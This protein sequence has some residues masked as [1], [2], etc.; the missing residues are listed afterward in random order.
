MIGKPSPEDRN[1]YKEKL[2]PYNSIREYFEEAVAEAGVDPF[3][4]DGT[5]DTRY[6]YDE[7]NER[8]NAI[9]NELVELG[10][11]KGDRISFMIPNVPEFIFAL[12]GAQKVG[13]IPALVNPELK[14]KT[15]EHCLSLPDANLLVTTT[16][17][18]DDHSEV[19]AAVDYEH[20]PWLIEGEKPLSAVT[21]ESTREFERILTEG[22]TT[23]PPDFDIVDDDPAVIPYSSG[24]TGMPKGILN[25]QK[26]FHLFGELFTD[27]GKMETG[28][29]YLNALP[30][31]HQ[32][33]LWSI[34]VAIAC[35]GYNVIFESFSISEFWER[36]DTYNCSGTC[37]VNE[38]GH[39]L[40]N[41]PEQAD[42]AD[43]PL[44][45]ALIFG[46]PKEEREAFESRFGIEYLTLYGMTEIG[47]AVWSKSPSKTDAKPLSDG[48]PVTHEVKIVDEHDR[49]LGPGEVGEVLAR[50]CLDNI[51]LKEY[52]DRPK[53]TVEAFQNCWFHTGDMGRLDEDGFFYYEGREGD[54]IRRKGENIS[55]AEIETV[56]N[57]LGGVFESAVIGVPDD[58]V[59]EEI[60]LHVITTEDSIS[61][62]DVVGYCAEELPGFQM[63]RYV[64]LL[65]EFPRTH[66]ERVQK[67]A[68]SERGEDGLTADT[69]DEK[70]GEFVG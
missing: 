42:D 52:V 27:Y 37:L 60:K 36:A 40:Y 63:P 33:G 19:R 48:R 47:G 3:V 66:T 70:A 64:E 59:G 13:V 45:W 58:Q 5:T 53:R 35:R 11:G 9:A 32:G 4:I 18:I 61:V 25:P 65:E 41:Q 43:N 49:E 68:L 51:I 50:P 34:Y 62:E 6:T 1:T 20:D 31:F 67:H 30:L 57:S 39:W 55:H 10:L 2:A 23:T 14:G 15:L 54:F 46:G 24:T 17:I 29:G 16:D 38:M 8:I 22:D 26:M 56:I 7:A 21:A 12:L 44:T 69:W 28:A